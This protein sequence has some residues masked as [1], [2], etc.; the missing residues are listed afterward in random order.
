MIPLVSQL[1]D[2][3]RRALISVSDKRDIASFAKSLH[4]LSFEIVSTGGTAAALREAG[5][6]V[7][8]VAELTG[9]PEIMDGRVKT[10]HP[11]VHAGLLA[12]AGLDDAVLAAHG[13]EA[14]DLLAVN[15]YPFEQVTARADV[16]FA[17]AIENIDIGGPAMLRAAAKNH[18]RVTVVV[19]PAD[20]AR[21]AEAFRSGVPPPALRRSLAAK[22]FAH[23]ARYDGLIGRYLAKQSAADDAFPEV[24]VLGWEKAGFELRY[25]ENPQQLAALYLDEQAVGGSVAQGRLLQGKPLSYNNLLDAGAAAACVGS[26]NVPACAIVKHMNPCGVAVAE[27]LTRAYEA[28]YAGDPVSAFGGIIAFNRPLDRGAAEAIVSRQRADV[29]TAPAVEEGARAA[30]A[31]KPNVR[32]IET[33][34]PSRASERLE[35]RSIAGGVLVQQPDDAAIGAAELKTVTRRAPDEPELRDLLFAWS[36]VKYVKSNAIVYAKGGRTLGIGAGQTSRVMSARIAGLKAAEQGLALAGAVMASDAFLPFR[37]GLDAAAEL[38]IRAVIQPGGSVRDK[39][40][41]DAAN[42]H[43]I[44]MVF[45]GMRHFR[46]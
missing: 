28:A 16:G 30:L 14:F 32:V 5:V 13:I 42:E 31:V 20:Y 40:V 25:G 45:T 4:D 22:V 29:I 41:I 38:G 1:V 33:G 6:P 18:E 15:L 9:F 17:E 36:V 43:G 27:N 44:A 23:T 12:R 24:L 37:D 26:L 2:K 19:D 46:H 21:V 39:E 10:L 35:I 7:V 34:E 11:K 8:D 3:R